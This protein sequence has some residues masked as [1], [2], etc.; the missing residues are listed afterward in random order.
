MMLP[1]L[2]G[3]AMSGRSFASQCHD[4]CGVV[5]KAVPA[6]ARCPLWSARRDCMVQSSCRRRQRSQ[7]LLLV[8]QASSSPAPSGGDPRIQQTRAAHR[9]NEWCVTGPTTPGRRV[10]A[11]VQLQGMADALYFHQPLPTR[12]QPPTLAPCFAAGL[13]GLPTPRPGWPR[14]WAP[15]RRL[16]RRVT[17]CCPSSQCRPRGRRCSA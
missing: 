6:A 11:D 3:L 8:P 16:W 2:P 15:P 17:T 9:Q 12:K 10:P 7:P 14:S 4:G 5:S 1:G 13:H